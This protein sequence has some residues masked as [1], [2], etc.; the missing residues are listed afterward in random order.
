MTES[1]DGGIFA[2]RVSK[3]TPPAVKP[4]AEVKDQAVAAWQADKRREK[5]A[6]TAEE[7]AA[8]VKPDIGLAAVAAERGFK[9]ATS[10]RCRAGPAATTRH[11][12]PFVAKLFAAKPGE[13]VT[14]ADA[15]G[16]Y[17]AQLTKVEIPETPPPNVVTDL[18]RELTAAMRGDLTAEY[19]PGPA[20]ALSRRNPPRGGRP[21]VL[22]GLGRLS[23]CR[24]SRQHRRND[25]HSDRVRRG[26]HR[27]WVK[28]HG[29]D[30]EM[31]VLDRHDDPVLGLC[32]DRELRRQG[33]CAGRRA[34]DSGRP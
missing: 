24:E 27:F 29:G 25:R 34:N 2:V 19:T 17:V 4:L 11:R 33:D 5:V 14:A 16:S 21:A 9:A 22:S 13:V 18:G 30:R 23:P 32:G 8:A 20:P 6:R 31:S 26:H 7:L 28:L 12:R 1:P 3:V 15:T 10:R